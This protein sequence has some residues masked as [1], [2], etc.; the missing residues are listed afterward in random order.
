M[1]YENCSI[2]ENI[3]SAECFLLNVANDNAREKSM[4]ESRE[5]KY[6]KKNFIRSES[7]LDED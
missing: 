4:G 1:K 6:W 2:V 5:I 7:T 3:A